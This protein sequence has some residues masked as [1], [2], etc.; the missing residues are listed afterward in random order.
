MGSI[1][2]VLYTE[3]KKKMLMQAP[4]HHCNVS[5]TGLPNHP[6]L[7]LN[8]FPSPHRFLYGRCKN[9]LFMP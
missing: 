1:T 5:W 2:R 7:A 8:I 9:S 3:S 6:F 4:K